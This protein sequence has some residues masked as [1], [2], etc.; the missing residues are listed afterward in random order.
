MT[1]DIYVGE[2][3]SYAGCLLTL[4]AVVAVAGGIAY[5]VWLRP[6]FKG[7]RTAVEPKATAVKTVKSTA[8]APTLTTATGKDIGLAAL[9]EVRALKQADK[10]QE[11]REKAYQVLD[12]SANPVARTEAESVLSEVN[13]ELVLSQRAMPEKTDYTVQ[14][15]DSLAALA[16]KYGTT[17]DVIQ[18]SNR[19]TGQTIRAGDRLRIFSGKFSIQVSKTRNDLV[20]LLNDRFFKRYRV[21][22]GQY[23]KTPTGSFF[24]KDKIP[25][26]PWWR[27]D[28][29]LIPFGDTNNVLGTRWMALSSTDN[30]PVRGYGIHGTWEPDTIGKQASA[31]CIRLLNAEVEQLFSLVPEGT[32]VTITE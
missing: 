30:V 27:P 2:S 10:L 24:I 9:S 22:T 6:H 32:T 17:V 8:P 7:E 31:G 16:R 1:D 18:K 28:G 21:G 3:K 4:L 14:P 23:G 25:S 5:F 19:L 20:L 26:P 12:K 13:V 29:K 11:A 15:G